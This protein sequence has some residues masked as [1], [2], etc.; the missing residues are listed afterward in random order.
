MAPAAR[1][2]HLR[3]CVDPSTEA[4]LAI[5][6]AREDETCSS[7]DALLLAPRTR[8][9][10]GRDAPSPADRP[11]SEPGDGLLDFCIDLGFCA[12]RCRCSHCPR[13]RSSEV[14][15]SAA[16]IRP[17]F[18]S[19][20]TLADSLQSESGRIGQLR[21]G[22]F[23]EPGGQHIPDTRPEVL[24]RTVLLDPGRTGRFTGESP[25]AGP[26][27]AGVTHLEGYQG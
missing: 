12:S 13:R 3:L 24:P 9:A 11:N 21:G 18:N 22:R 17:L 27:D 5:P 10:G 19:P 6:G 26:A 16:K 23:P 4:R 14:S 8:A 1:P 25:L 20:V 2:I 7:L 15:S